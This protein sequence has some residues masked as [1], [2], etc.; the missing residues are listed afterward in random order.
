MAAASLVLRRVN[1]LADLQPALLTPA[2]EIELVGLAPG[3]RLISAILEYAILAG[4]LLSP[5]LKRASTSWCVRIGRP[6]M[7]LGGMHHDC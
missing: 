1:C 3:P 6:H 2:R 7:V 4:S 5:V